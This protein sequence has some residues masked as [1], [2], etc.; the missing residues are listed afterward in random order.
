MKKKKT[1]RLYAFIVIVLAVA[2]LAAGILILFYLQG[3]KISGNEYCT[4]QE[5]ADVI[6]QDKGS[7]NT[8]YITAKYALGYGETLPC[9]E[10]MKVSMKN[11]WTLQV[12]V[13]EKPIVG[14]VKE[15]KHYFYF[16]KT[17]LV[18]DESDSLTE[19]LPSITGL[20]V[21]N[22]ELYQTL[23]CDDPGIFEEILETSKE[24]KKYELDQVKIQCEDNQI[25][26]E[27]GKVK[28]NLGSSVS[29][30]QIAQIKPI[31]EKLGDREGTLHL[32]D[33][34]E[35]GSTIT[36]DIEESQDEISEEK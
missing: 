30:E 1:H 11:P 26:L 14:Y 4:D 24:I 34:S 5:I 13:E 7:F 25:F 6:E 19:G 28:V 8:I 36:F 29:S 18:V 32:E 16:D 33:Y 12:K 17:G 21:K 3:I 15:G 9:L 10:S 20:K 22:L 2:I 23:E 27:I 35:S 31:L